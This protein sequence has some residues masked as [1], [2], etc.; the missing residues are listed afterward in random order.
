MELVDVRRIWDRGVHNAFTDLI[1]F[2]DEWICV[3][4][5]GD[6]HVSPDGVLR[7]IASDDGQAWDA[8]GRIEDPTADLRDAKI[9]RTPKGELMLS[10]AA[11]PHQGPLQSYSWFSTDGRAAVAAAV[12]RMPSVQ[13]VLISLVAGG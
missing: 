10:G 6:G 2:G 11:N 9:T 13:H 12:G 5:E 8:V 3:F 4:R 7:V 1:R